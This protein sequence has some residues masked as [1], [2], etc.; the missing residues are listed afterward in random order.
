MELSEDMKKFESG[1]N[2]GF[3]YAAQVVASNVLRL[4]DQH[5][6]WMLEPSRRQAKA[7]IRL[8]TKNILQKKG[9]IPSS[10]AVMTGKAEDVPVDFNLF[11]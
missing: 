6:S 3:F 1:Y 9:L 7:E 4:I 10:Y 11:I 2:E 8:A 5:P